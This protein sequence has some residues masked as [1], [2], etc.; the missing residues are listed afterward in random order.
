MVAGYVNTIG[1]D[2]KP[3]LPGWPDGA[4][5]SHEESHYV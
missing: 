1:I 3:G 2:R 5:D 4:S